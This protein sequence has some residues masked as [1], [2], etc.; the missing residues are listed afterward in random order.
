MSGHLAGARLLPWLTDDGRR[1]YAQDGGWLALYADVLEGDQLAMG[2]GLL[3][4]AAEI[5]NSGASEAE[6]RFLV[7]RLS[8]ALR[9]AL[10]V[11]ECRGERVADP[12]DDGRSDDGNGP[13]WAPPAEAFG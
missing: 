13:D 4:R 1:C 2:Y 11:A 3:D 10:R 5:V 8:E 12:D 6:L 9:D 7:E